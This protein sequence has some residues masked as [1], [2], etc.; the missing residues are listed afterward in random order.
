M[1][2]FAAA[3]R[4]PA[5]GAPRARLARNVIVDAVL[6]WIAIQVLERHGVPA[7]EAF[8]A[9]AIFPAGSIAHDWRRHRRVELIGL[10][11][12]MTLVVGIGLALF[13][14]DIRFAALKA[15][16]AFG[17]FGAACLVS[18]RGAR[19]LMFVVARYVNAGGDAAT[20]AEWDARLQSAAGFRRAMQRLTLVWGVACLAESALGT[21]VAFL[22]PPHTAVLVEPV[23]GIGTVAVLLAWT[24]FYAR[25]RGGTAPR[26]IGA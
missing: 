20:I 11:V 4:P 7:L 18:L 10:G 13:V 24:A 8:A 3:P 25:R 9:A 17:L 12:L 15:A 26:A 22:L 23:L 14:E 6:P 16:P 5:I 21:A 19:P 1:P 2:E